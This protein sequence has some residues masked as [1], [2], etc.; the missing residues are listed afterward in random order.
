MKL[1]LLLFLLF[2][3]FLISNPDNWKD[4]ALTFMNDV[5]KLVMQYFIVFQDC[6]NRAFEGFLDVIDHLVTEYF[7]VFQS[8]FNYALK[9]L[10]EMIEKYLVILQLLVTNM[11]SFPNSAV[12]MTGAVL[13]VY[14][15]KN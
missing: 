8:C 5:Y 7:E 12:Y 14:I 3:L 10:E 13:I 6:F 9:V 4:V 15:I 2:S 11:T 1:Y